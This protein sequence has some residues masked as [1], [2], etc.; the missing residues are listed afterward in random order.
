MNMIKRQY[1]LTDLKISTTNMIQ[2]SHQIIY[3]IKME[4]WRE[5]SHHRVN[6]SG[7]KSQQYSPYIDTHLRT[8]T[9]FMLDP[10]TG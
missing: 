5:A 9:K 8:Y 6:R 1:I 4:L 10:T 2:I 3:L 7:S